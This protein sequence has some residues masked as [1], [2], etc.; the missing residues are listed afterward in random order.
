MFSGIKINVFHFILLSNSIATFFP[1]KILIGYTIMK[2]NDYL[3]ANILSG[4]LRI[5][6]AL[7]RMNPSLI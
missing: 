5:S 1:I 6:E 4:I 3:Y 2:F 7:P